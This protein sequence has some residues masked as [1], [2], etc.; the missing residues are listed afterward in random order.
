M[1]KSMPKGTWRPHK[2]RATLSN[3]G[4]NKLSGHCSPFSLAVLGLRSR[5]AD[6][7]VYRRQVICEVW[8][9]A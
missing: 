5:A 3:V 4:K 7:D 9:N 1:P 8:K 2:G 6:I